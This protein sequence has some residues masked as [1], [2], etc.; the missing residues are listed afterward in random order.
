MKKNTFLRVL[1]CCASAMILLGVALTVYVCQ[2]AQ[3]RKMIC[4]TLEKDQTQT[5]EFETLELSPGEECEY[6]ISLEKGKTESCEVA[7]L[8]EE[9]GSATIAKYT[10]V[11]IEM[12]G[13]VLYEQKLSESFSD[14]AITFGCDFSEQESYEV[15]VIYYMPKDIGN[16][17]QNAQADF[18]LNITASNMGDK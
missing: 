3:D 14:E 17:A 15:T 13:E 4:I 5:V 6:T 10:Y 7:F 8:F 9:A 11:R 2:T 16:E 18:V 1:L 12:N